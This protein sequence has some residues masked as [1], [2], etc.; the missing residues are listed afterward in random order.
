MLH[1]TFL[2]LSGRVLRK[3]LLDPTEMELLLTRIQSG[4]AGHVVDDERDAGCRRSSNHGQEQRLGLL[5]VDELLPRRVKGLESD[6]ERVAAASPRSRCDDPRSQTGR[7]PGRGGSGG[8]RCAPALRAQDASAGR[9]GRRAISWH[10]SAR[11]IRGTYPL[12]K[13]RYL[14]K[15]AD[16]LARGKKMASVLQL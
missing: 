13:I 9:R 4:E 14:D 7:S 10:L 12:Q 5:L 8:A 1:R 16:E 11:V 15:L 2:Q 3:G 6:F